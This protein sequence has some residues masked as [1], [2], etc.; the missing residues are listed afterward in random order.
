M[1]NLRIYCTKESPT[2]ATVVGWTLSF[3]YRYTEV[4]NLFKEDIFSVMAKVCEA[5]IVPYNTNGYVLFKS[6]SRLSI[7]M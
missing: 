1:F 7:Q 3:E 4:T 6:L 5:I 2:L